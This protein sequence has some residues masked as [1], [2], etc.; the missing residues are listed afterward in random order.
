MN[1]EPR[2]AASQSEIQENLILSQS[3][4][5]ERLNALL[6]ARENWLDTTI[7]DLDKSKAEIDQLS[8]YNKDLNDQLSALEDLAC[9]S[10]SRAAGL[11]YQMRRKDSVSS[12][13]RGAL[14]LVE[15][16]LRYDL[17]QIRAF[18]NPEIS[19]IPF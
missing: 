7:A 13:Q 6:L 1:T 11:L 3:A 10:I 9:E 12:F 19:D 15:G 8:E 16:Y 5:I 4:E 17:Q 18:L 2:L 14:D